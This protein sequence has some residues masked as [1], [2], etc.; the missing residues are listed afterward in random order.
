MH[1]D[2]DLTCQQ[3]FICKPGKRSRSTPSAICCNPSNKPNNDDPPVFTR[4]SANARSQPVTPDPVA[5]PEQHRTVFN[6]KFV[7][8][9]PTPDQ[10]E[11]DRSSVVDSF[12]HRS[13]NI[14]VATGRWESV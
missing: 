2:C 11:S 3:Q 13:T 9:R 12:Q 14:P 6:A 8:N 1:H 4:R 10:W 5:Q 7:G